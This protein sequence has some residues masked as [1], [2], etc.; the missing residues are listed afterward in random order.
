MVR[1]TLNQQCVAYSATGRS[2][3][4]SKERNKLGKNASEMEGEGT[5]IQRV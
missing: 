4:V 2:D 3:L 5:A 1:K